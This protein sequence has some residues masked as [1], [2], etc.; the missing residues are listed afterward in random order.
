MSSSEGKTTNTREETAFERDTTCFSP[1]RDF[2]EPQSAEQFFGL[3]KGFLKKELD[4]KSKELEVKS[5]IDKET[6]EFKYKGNRKQYELN[7]YLDNA[8]SQIRSKA[9]EPSEVKK[10]AKEAEVHLKKRQKLIKLADRSKDGWLVVQEYESDD[11][12]SDSED[13]KKIKKAKNAAE[14]KRK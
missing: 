1:G 3:L 13:E 8:F 4:S 5:K 2:S 9:D 11:L 12:A 14:K 6:A 7:A 10:L